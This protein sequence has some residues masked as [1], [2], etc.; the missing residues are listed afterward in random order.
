[1]NSNYPTN[2]F[3]TGGS[4]PT[5]AVAANFLGDVFGFTGLDGLLLNSQ[6]TNAFL[7]NLS[8]KVG[9]YVDVNDALR[10]VVCTAIGSD[11]I[12]FTFGSIYDHVFKGG[13]P[14]SVASY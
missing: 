13:A 1:M 7:Q 14:I 2:E 8:S 6:A 3:M 12:N 5:T 10:L 4:V 9:A 11:G